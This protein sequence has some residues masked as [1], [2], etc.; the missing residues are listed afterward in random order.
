[1]SPHAVPSIAG[2]TGSCYP[3][4]IPVVSAGIRVGMLQVVVENAKVHLPWIAGVPKLPSHVVRNVVVGLLNLEF[5]CLRLVLIGSGN[6]NVE[7]VC[8]ILHY[9]TDVVV[10]SVQPV[11]SGIRISGD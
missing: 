9:E 10:I 2:K 7:L 6:E 1:M 5:E 8:G 3:G 11:S 4:V